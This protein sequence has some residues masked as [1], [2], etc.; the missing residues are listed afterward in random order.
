MKKYLVPSKTK[1]NLPDIKCEY[2]ASSSLLGFHHDFTKNRN[3]AYEFH[4]N[5]LEHAKMLSDAWKMDLE[6]V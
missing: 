1:G 3:K 6:K 2:I 5:E 4:E